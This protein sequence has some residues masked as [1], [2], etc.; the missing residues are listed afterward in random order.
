M[1]SF[2]WAYEVSEGTWM[3]K[4]ISFMFHVFC[5]CFLFVF[6]WCLFFCFFVFFSTSAQPCVRLW[7]LASEYRP[8]HFIADSFG[9]AVQRIW[10]DSQC[11]CFVS[12]VNRQAIHTAHSLLSKK[13]L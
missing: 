5:V 10:I 8:R 4:N 2:H 9:L 3:A 1:S 11:T 7:L 13:R 12:P 6:F